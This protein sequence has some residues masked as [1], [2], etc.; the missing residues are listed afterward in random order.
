MFKCT[1]F[2]SLCPS[3]KVS[4]A[5]LSCE[6]VKYYP[7]LYDKQIKGYK[8]KDVVRNEWNSGAKDLEFIENGISKLIVFFMLYQE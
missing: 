5:G 1:F 3:V 7:A 4:L 6:E 8:E 2:S